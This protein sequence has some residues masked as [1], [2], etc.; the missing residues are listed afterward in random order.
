MMN[1]GVPIHHK[2]VDFSKFSLPFSGRA[3]TPSKLEHFPQHT[4]KRSWKGEEKVRMVNARTTKTDIPSHIH[5][6]DRD[7]QEQTH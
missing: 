5:M 1:L 7:Q 3:D 6:I 4:E 2:Q